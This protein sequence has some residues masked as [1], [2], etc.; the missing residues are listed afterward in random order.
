LQVKKR[1]KQTLRY[2]FQYVFIFTISPLELARAKIIVS[3]IDSTFTI[4]K[5][6]IVL[7]TYAANEHALSHKNLPA[8]DV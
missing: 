1:K 3:V 2:S 8:F 7:K 6:T 5:L 4:V